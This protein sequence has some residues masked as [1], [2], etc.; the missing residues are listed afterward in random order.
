MRRIES[1]KFRAMDM[2]GNGY[3]YTISDTLEGVK[4][5]IDASRER[6]IKAGYKPD[7]YRITHTEYYTWL[8]D[9]GSFIKSET[10]EQAVEVYPAEEV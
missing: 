8:D 4:A 5:E 3:L 9:D 2:A 7:R 6:Q 1:D 10:L